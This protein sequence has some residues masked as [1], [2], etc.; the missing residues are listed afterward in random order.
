MEK[1]STIIIFDE[2]SFMRHRMCS[3]FQGYDV[4][5]L[6]AANEMDLFHHL[7]DSNF[8]IRLI[9]MDLGSDV[10]T[11]L[12]TL[13]RIKE[14][15]P[16]IPV[17]IITSHNKRMIF[18]KCIAE[19]AS[20]YILKPFDDSYLLNKA[21]STINHM[22]KTST[23][24]TH[25]VFDIRNYLNSE[26]KKATK[27][28]YE[29]SVLMCA[30]YDSLKDSTTMMEN[31]YARFID[32]FYKLMKENLW[33]TDIFERYGLQ[34][35]I[36]LFPYCS[37]FNTELVDKKIHQC[38]QTIQNAHHEISTLNI[39]VTTMTYPTDISD[40]KDLLY[41]LGIQLH[42]EIERLNSP[43]EDLT[44]EPVDEWNNTK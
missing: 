34:T 1:A 25:L 22:K 18:L 8:N 20:D 37:A 4:Q 35:F 29:V 39:A 31:K 26:L 30:I 2:V 38:F 14:R 21:L 27:G 44:E 33:D 17:F 10:T 40:P 16:E 15:K 24:P 3:L 36:G 28:N 12:N 9:L 7:S 42:D 19:G 23:E 5:V 32:E 6:E 41:H 13:S 43:S 11:G